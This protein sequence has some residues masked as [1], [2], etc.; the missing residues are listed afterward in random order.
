MASVNETLSGAS[1]TTAFDG[2][3]PI[4]PFLSVTL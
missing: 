3:L 2:L 1:T 4:I